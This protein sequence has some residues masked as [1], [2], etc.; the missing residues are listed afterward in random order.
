MMR[1][2]AEDMMR[3]TR[4]ELEDKARVLGLE[5]SDRKKYQSKM[6]IA[7]AILHKKEMKRAEEP[8]APVSRVVTAGKKGVYAKRTAINNQVVENEEAVAN[9]GVEI[10]NFQGEMADRSR[11]IRAG[12]D[13]MC[14]DIAGLK[15][16]IDTSVKDIF[17]N[18]RELQSSIKEQSGKNAKAAANMGA[19]VKAFKGEISAKRSDM[20]RYSVDFKRN[21]GNFEAD[22]SAFGADMNANVHRLRDDIVKFQDITANYIK[23]FYFG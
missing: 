1:E 23:D 21:V 16:S 22:M 14:K 4:K 12:A 6:D 13:Q 9:I 10:R 5:V 17:D 19:S 20:D 8:R 18:V 15:I 3:F 7:H 11:H 2:T